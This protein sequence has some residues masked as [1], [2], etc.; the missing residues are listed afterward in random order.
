M[1]QGT[2][3][4]DAEFIFSWTCTVVMETTTK[5]SFPCETLMEQLT[6]NFQ[7]DSSWRKFLG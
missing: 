2:F 7:I 1:S 3:K 4:D 5:S 6:F